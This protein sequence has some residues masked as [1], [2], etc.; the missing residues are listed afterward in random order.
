MGIPYTLL[1]QSNTT[2]L[3]LAYFCLSKNNFGVLFNAFRLSSHVVYFNLLTPWCLVFVSLLASY[4]VIVCLALV[5]S[6]WLEGFELPQFFF[7]CLSTCEMVYWA[8]PCKRK[9]WFGITNWASEPTKRKSWTDGP[10][11]HSAIW[12]KSTNSW[13]I[14]NLIATHFLQSCFAFTYPS[15]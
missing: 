7:L 3:T 9:R 2:L 10:A 13:C 12:S 11:I 14:I 4:G 15:Q 8:E 6:P 1:P 5:S